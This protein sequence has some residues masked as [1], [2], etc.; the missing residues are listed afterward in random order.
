MDW[1]LYDNGLRHERVK[2]RHKIKIE[3]RQNRTKCCCGGLITFLEQL[4]DFLEKKILFCGVSFLHHP[5]K[6]MKK[7]VRKRRITSRNMQS[8]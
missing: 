7:S 6:N 5:M 2:C 4:R 3:F 1:F 8:K